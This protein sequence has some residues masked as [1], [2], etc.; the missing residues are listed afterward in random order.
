MRAKVR[1]AID[2]LIAPLFCCRIV[3]RCA[4]AALCFSPDGQRLAVAF[5]RG[6]LHVYRTSN[7]K[8]VV[9]LDADVVQPDHGI[10]HA[11]FVSK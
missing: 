1:R 4:I 5:S 10:I 7:G 8:R 11:L 2:R 6:A 3:E 9:E